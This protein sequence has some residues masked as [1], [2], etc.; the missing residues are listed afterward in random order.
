LLFLILVP[1]AGF[2][3]AY[4]PGL[5]RN[6]LDGDYYYQVARHVAE[7]DGLVTSVSLYHQG[8]KS[9]PHP[10]NIYPLWP[11][12]LGYA[13]RVVPLPVA[14]AVLPEA[15]FFAS[16]LLLY[17]LAN[18][19]AERLRGR[20]EPYVLGPGRVLDLGH[21]AVMLFGFN[22]VFFN[23]T[24]LPYTE[25]IGYTL[26]FGALLALDRSAS[27]RRGLGW[28]AAAG[29]LAALAYLARVQMV[30]VVPAVV[31]ALALAGLRR[32]ERLAAAGVA[33]AAAIL[34]VLPWVLHL[35]SFIQPFEPWVLL[36]FGAYRETP[37][38]EPFGS[39]LPIGPGW[40]ARLRDFAA[41][42]RAA[43]DPRGG[44]TSYAGSFGLA[45]FVVPMALLHLALSRRRWRQL[46]GVLVRPEGAVVA[47]T[48]AAAAAMVLPLHFLHLR[49]LWEWRFGFR[50]GLSFGLLVLVAVAYLLAHGEPLVRRVTLVL[51][52][53]TL[54]TGSVRTAEVLTAPRGWGLLPAEEELVAWLD[55]RS[56]GPVV[57]TTNAQPLSVYSRAGF[58]WM[59]CGESAEKTRT[60]LRLLPIDYVLVYQAESGCPFI[61]GVP[62]LT[63][64]RRFGEGAGAVWVLAPGN[65][66]GA[67]PQPD[68][69]R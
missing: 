3:A 61:R 10:T 19:L 45:A 26:A 51:L 50:H 18:R 42:L 60:I 4:D 32:R 9:L 29:A 37:E 63:P 28:A 49:F 36:E 13:G 17:P 12:V 22:A 7:G 57:L 34:V 38:I 43:F 69:R 8:F 52:A 67:G 23:F 59:E 44:V 40:W 5:G 48:A 27:G 35:A 55:A 62:E 58:H 25:G 66:G 68:G 41:G 54:V 33:A 21:V 53:F 24:S 1:L 30:M 20:P 56:P 15:F 47:A 31:A 46:A 64:V 14:A 2:K 39:R 11:L 16:L 65:G 6:S